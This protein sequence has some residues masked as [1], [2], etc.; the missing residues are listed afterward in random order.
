MSSLFVL[1]LTGVLSMDQ[2]DKL[3]MD[4]IKKIYIKQEMKKVVVDWLS[5]E[6]KIKTIKKIRIIMR[7]KDHDDYELYHLLTESSQARLRFRELKSELEGLE[8]FWYK[9]FGKY[10]MIND[11]KKL[12]LRK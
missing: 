7:Q 4:T 5:C 9:L 1:V 11:E 10:Q 12:L 8:D 6:I 3:A 2:S